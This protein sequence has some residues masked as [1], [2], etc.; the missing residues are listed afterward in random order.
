MEFMNSMFG[1][2]TAPMQQTAL[3]ADDTAMQL[4]LKRRLKMAEALQQQAMPEGQMVSGHYVA[5]SWTQ[6]LANAY[7]KYQGGKQEREALGQY[8]DYQAAKAKK[9][10]DLMTD[11]AKGKETITTDNTP[12]QVQVPGGQEQQQNNL[13]G[14]QPIG[15]KFIDVPNTTKTSTFSPY[16]KQ[17]YMDK[18]LQTIPELAPKVL[19]TSLASQFKDREIDYK[20][21]GNQLVPVYKD[22]GAVVPGLNPLSKNMTPE[23]ERQAKWEQF[24]F[25]NPSASDLLSAS[26]A[27]RGQNIQLRGQ[28]LVDARSHQANDIASGKTIFD[29]TN[30]LRND[31]TQLPEVKAWN[32]IQPTLVSA[33]EAAKDT[34]GGSDLNLIYAM[35]KVMD[36]NSVVREGELQMAGNTGSLG[37]RIAGMYKSVAN[38]GHLTA[39]VKNDLMSQIESRAKAQENLYN[40]TKTKYTD[41]AKQYNLNPNELF[42][43]GI[44]T[45]D[46]NTYAPLPNVKSMTQNA[47]KT[48]VKTGTDKNTGRKVVQYSDGTTEYVK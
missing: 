46:T 28:N 39:D 24:K 35:G 6:Y 45:P 12:F 11:L 21:L 27:Q 1:D 44:T 36:P 30:T 14:M 38:G 15:T 16:S 13:G 40:K 8:G 34:T 42:V 25:A 26:T 32:V 18:V 41:I 2:N 5:P 31:F 10:G 20:D 48:I 9:Y 29:R 37:Q 7:G 43:E 23:Q 33:R 19:E 3:P 17:E 4:E 22:T 47:P